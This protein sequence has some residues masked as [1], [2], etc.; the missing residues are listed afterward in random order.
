MSFRKHPSDGVETGIA[1]SLDTVTKDLSDPPD[2]H[3]TRL[4]A[5]HHTPDVFKSQAG[6]VTTKTERQRTPTQER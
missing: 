2:S 5:G 6:K 4:S 1:E 3:E